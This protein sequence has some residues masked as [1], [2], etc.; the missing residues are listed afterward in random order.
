MERKR[1]KAKPTE[2]PIL[3]I[4]RKSLR[5]RYA[6]EDCNKVREI[7][8]PPITK[9]KSSADP[10]IIKSYVSGRQVNRVYM[11][12]GS[13]CEVIYEH[14]FLKLKPSIRSLRIDSKT[15]LVGFSGEYS[16][17][18]GEVPLCQVGRN[19]EVNADEM[20]IKS[21]F[22][23]EMLADIR[24][25]LE[26]LRVINLKLNLKKCS[27]GVEEGRFLGH[28]I[29]KQ[30]IKVDLSKVKAILD[31][32]PPKS[33]SEMQ[34]LGQ[35]LAVISRFLSKG[36]DKM[37]PFMRTLKNCMSG[38]MIQWTTKADEAFRRMKEL[39]KSYI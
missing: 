26:R 25:T 12:S 18:L 17:P 38:K 20:V 32:Q 22:E 24:E 16:W 4:S 39:L 27:F 21:N 3:I 31:L 36:A 28:L 34:S 10:V 13:S 5:K 2:T 30:G 15:L 1:K 37:L 35:K 14:C 9:D 33:I 7:T 23:E 8:F 11:D 6:E 29:T 19:I